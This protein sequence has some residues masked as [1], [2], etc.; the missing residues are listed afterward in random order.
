MSALPQKSSFTSAEYLALLHESDTRFELLEGELV[1]M[2]GASQRHITI[3]DN[4]FA[5]LHMRLRGTPCRA[6]HSE[7]NVRVDE[8]HTFPD[9]SVVCGERHFA[10][11]EPI[12]V[13]LNPTLVIEVLSPSTEAYDRGKKF[14]IYRKVVQDY[15]LVSQHIPR[16]ECLSRG[17]DATWI[18]RQA[19]GLEATIY[20]PSID[21]MLLLADVYEDVEYAG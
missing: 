8:S 13:L 2:A 3:T 10:Q 16:I 4:L 7:M 21:V 5:L 9:I 17:P 15:V 20:L 14:Q 1:A 18:H 6:Y 11:N 19:D 12:A